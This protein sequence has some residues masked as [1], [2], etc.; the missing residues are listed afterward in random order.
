M[1]GGQATR[2]PRFLSGLFPRDP[3][4][5]QIVALEKG[6]GPVETKTY[7]PE[8]EGGEIVKMIDRHNGAQHQRHVY[9]AVNETTTPGKKAK[10]SEIGHVRA[11]HVDIDCGESEEAQKAALVRLFRDRPPGVPEPTAVVFSGGGYWAFWALAEPIPV[12]GDEKLAENLRDVNRRLAEAF[13]AEGG[14]SC[15]DLSRIARLPGSVNWA[16]QKGGGRSDRLATV[17]HDD[18]SGGK[19][20]RYSLSDFLKLPAG[21]PKA[22]GGVSLGDAGAEGPGSGGGRS[23]PPVAPAVSFADLGYKVGADGAPTEPDDLAAVIVS[24]PDAR[25]LAAPELRDRWRKPDGRWDR[26]LA[27]F[28]V[29]AEL[30]R[31][32]VAPELI[33]RAILEPTWAISDH[34]HSHVEGDGERPAFLREMYARRQVERAMGDNDAALAEKIAAPE[35]PFLYGEALPWL[36]ARFATIENYGG[37]YRVMTRPGVDDPTLPTFL[38]APQWARRFDGFRTGVVDPKTGEVKPVAL[39]DVWLGDKSRSRFN[40]VVFD[41]EGEEPG[42][43]LYNLWTG[44][45][46][47][48]AATTCDEYLRLTREVIAAGSEEVYEY[49]IRWMALRVQRPGQ[50][51]EVAIALRG[52]QGLGKSLWAELFGELF[53]PHFIAVSGIHGLAHNFNKHLLQ[54]LLVFGDEMNAAGDRATVSKL[55]TLVTQ[56]HIQIE[57]KGVDSF[58]APNRFA[59]IVASNGAKVVDVDPDDRRWL[60]LD[61]APTWKGQF[62]RFASLVKS[63]RDGG[64]REAFLDYL[65]SL[66]LAGYNHRNRPLTRTHSEQIV[67]SFQGAERI[68]HAMLELGATPPIRR[69]NEERH[70]PYRQGGEV[71]VPTLDALDWARARGLAGR[72]EGNLETALG[73][74]MAKAA[75]TKSLRYSVHGKQVRGFWLAPLPE[76]RRRWAA[77]NGLDIDWSDSGG[78]WDVIPGQR[79]PDAAL[80]E[81]RE[82]PF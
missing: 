5:V 31:R 29:C 39:A 3:R 8:I 32:G 55:K 50:K 82:V 74:E 75:V 42:D 70:C 63:W 34:L 1:T 35:P 7:H 43:R 57:P 79:D 76:A 59:L 11:F 62:D 20:R 71:F 6:K 49:L 38:A 66:D 16:S 58:T 68:M 28:Y 23:C 61:V 73:R 19:P 44:F 81:Q 65:L 80:A 15:F 14:D 51:L 21:K 27:V 4:K 37:S 12:S 69:G 36:N 26:S 45:R 64:G 72:F 78:N 17:I 46:R 25:D 13:A 47:Q 53:G 30:D 10:A 56:T 33:A 48:N 41:P 2:A 60:A 18:W 52:G 40:R 77:E 9:F 24:G 67:H 22:R 54:A